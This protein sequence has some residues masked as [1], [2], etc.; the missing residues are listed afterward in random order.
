MVTPPDF[1][2]AS[3]T[4]LHELADLRR[5]L[6]EKIA[7]AEPGAAAG[8]EAARRSLEAAQTAIRQLLEQIRAGRELLA[9]PEARETS[10]HAAAPPTDRG[11]GWQQRN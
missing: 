7:S 1:H 8:L 9:G 5:L 6:D 11:P 10:A 3:A 4:I 2:T